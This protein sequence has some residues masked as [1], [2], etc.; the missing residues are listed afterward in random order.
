MIREL[1]GQAI[2]AAIRHFDGVQVIVSFSGG[3]DQGSIENNTWTILRT[4][5]PDGSQKDQIIYSDF[6]E[7][8]CL[9]CV[10]IEK[11]KEIFANLV[12]N[13]DTKGSNTDHVFEDFLYSP[14]PGFDGEG[15]VWGTML[16]DAQ[17]SKM[18]IV[19]SFQETRNVLADPYEEKFTIDSDDTPPESFF[20]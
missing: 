6:H 4:K 1:M 15:S 7:S 14:L 12:A 11:A 17:E 5:I 13:T 2:F 3:G 19:H 20:K 9:G 18:V 10:F 8:D 16:F